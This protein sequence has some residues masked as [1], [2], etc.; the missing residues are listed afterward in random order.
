M[1]QTKLHASQYARFLSIGSL[2]LFLLLTGIYVYGIH[3]GTA[4]EWLSSIR[5]LG[6][7]GIILGIIIQAMVNAIPAPG[8]FVSV[9][10][11]EIYGPV[12]GGFYSWIG[13]ILGAFLAYHLSTWIARPMIEPLA[14]P[15]LKKADQWLQK[16]GKL[17]LLLIRFVPLVPYH[18]INY[19]AGILRVNKKAFIWTT[20]VGI[21]PFTISVSI[22]FAGFRSGGF[23]SFMLSAIL[24]SL[25]FTVSVVLR[26]KKAVGI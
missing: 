18:F 22:L 5:H 23:F 24:F 3:T 6:G 8:E 13:G 17:G 7:Y 16:Q 1:E 19:A 25:S 11:I 10:L 14:K 4:K 12:A 20:A 15:Y 21:L 2:T 26:R 9:F